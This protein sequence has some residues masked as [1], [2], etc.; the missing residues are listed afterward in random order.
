M[1]W[2]G[3]AGFNAIGPFSGDHL[4]DFGG[5]LTGVFLTDTLPTAPPSTLRF[6]ISNSSEGGIQTDFTVLDP[7]IGQVFFIG[8]GLTGTGSGRLAK[9]DREAGKTRTGLGR[10]DA[11]LRSFSPAGLFHGL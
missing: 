2:F 8:D 10:A 9:R 4:T 1:L 7:E 3:G 11:P 6:Y 5:P